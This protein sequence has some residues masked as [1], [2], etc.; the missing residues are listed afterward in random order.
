MSSAIRKQRVKIV[1]HATTWWYVLLVRKKIGKRE[2]TTNLESLIAWEML[3][4]IIYPCTPNLWGRLYTSDVGFVTEHIAS[5]FRWAE[6]LWKQKEQELTLQHPPRWF[7]QGVLRPGELLW[8]TPISFCSEQRNEGSLYENS[9]SALKKNLNWPLTTT[10]SLSSL[11]PKAHIA[12]YSNQSYDCLRIACTEIN[13]NPENFIDWPMMENTVSVIII[14]G[15]AEYKFGNL[16]RETRAGPF[17][18]DE[19]ECAAPH[20]NSSICCQ[21]LAA[22]CSPPV[23]ISVG[24]WEHL[25][26]TTYLPRICTSNNFKPKRHWAVT[27]GLRSVSQPKP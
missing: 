14:V 19:T 16:K 1:L 5:D 23:F 13:I 17:G 7:W 2:K 21:Q 26:P 11:Y 22:C 25:C 15:V 10:F 6:L 4:I 20:P 27:P 24:S 3:K 8:N 9:I 18:S 12:A